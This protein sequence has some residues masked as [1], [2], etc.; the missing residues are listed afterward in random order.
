MST[1]FVELPVRDL[2][3]ARASAAGRRPWLPAREDG[4]TY[5]SS[6][7]DPHGHAWQVTW[8]DQQHVVDRPDAACDTPVLRRRPEFLEQPV[9]PL[10]DGDHRRPAAD[11]GGRC[12]SRPALDEDHREATLARADA[13]WWLGRVPYTRLKATLSPKPLS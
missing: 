5:T 4:A 8:M 9:G 10:S 13:R 1:L 6:F 11:A 12:C 3:V 2:G 7:A